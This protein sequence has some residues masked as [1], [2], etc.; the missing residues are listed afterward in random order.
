MLIKNLLYLQVI[1]KEEIGNDKCDYDYIFLSQLLLLQR[2]REREREKEGMQK[3]HKR[4]LVPSF[5]F[6][7]FLFMFFFKFQFLFFFLVNAVGNNL[8]KHKI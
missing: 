2:E 8:R 6:C 1:F 5:F 3:D 7:L 4:N